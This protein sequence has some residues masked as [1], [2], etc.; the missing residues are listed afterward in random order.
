VDGARGLIAIRGHLD[1]VGAD[2]LSGSVM[3][4]QR[5]GRR[6]I[7]VRLRPGATVDADARRALTALARRMS[8]E[9]VRLGIP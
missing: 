3:A 2:L 7:R 8:A 6:R 4:L 1:E 9:G 5:L